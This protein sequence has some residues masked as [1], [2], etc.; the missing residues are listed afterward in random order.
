MDS[1]L[2]SDLQLTLRA[3]SFAARV[4]RTQ[5]LPDGATPYYAHV[6]RVTW[7]LRHL[8][9]VRD[10]AT[11][12]AAILH[13]VLEDT[14]VTEAELAAEFGEQVAGWV[15]NLSKKQDLPE[16]DRESDYA[17]RLA[18]A[19]ERVCLV[20]LADAYDNLS[21]R[22]GTAKLPKTLRNVRRYVDAVSGQITSGAGREALGHVRQLMREVEAEGPES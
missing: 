18:S 21:S 14:A 19:P 12:V 15:A 17:K 8:F 22:R 20:K 9:D 13:D 3:F 7:I 6:T 10:T 11:L 16:Q 2:T 4:H 1:E 5:T